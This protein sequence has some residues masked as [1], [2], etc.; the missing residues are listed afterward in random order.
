MS[1]G[2]TAV[3]HGSEAQQAL[4]VLAGWGWMQEGS[5]HTQTQQNGVGKRGFE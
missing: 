2:V 5:T 1:G 3:K 4:W